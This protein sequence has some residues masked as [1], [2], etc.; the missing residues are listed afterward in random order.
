MIY[1]SLPSGCRYEVGS[2]GLLM[3]AWLPWLP[4]GSGGSYAIQTHCWFL[5]CMVPY[6]LLFDLLFRKVVLR[7]TTLSAGCVSLLLLALPPWIAFFVPGSLPEGD[8]KWYDSPAPLRLARLGPEMA[9][10]IHCAFS[11]LPLD[12]FACTAFPV[13][14]SCLHR[15]LCLPHPHR[16]RYSAHRVGALKS[17]VDYAI[18]TL[19][20]HPVCYLHVFVFGMVLARTRSLLAAELGA[21]ATGRSSVTGSVRREALGA[22]VL[23]PLFRFG[24]T[25]GYAGLAI[26][27]LVRGV[28]IQSPAL[29]TR[30]SILMPLQV[31]AIADAAACTTLLPRSPPEVL[32]LCMLPTQLD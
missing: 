7:L 32:L 9:C 2:Q 14:S 31:G 27:F 4:E 17:A 30:L 21:M 3:Q 13:P 5:S 24:A 15:M 16:R 20:F 1:H 22:R 25:I 6:W 26:I 28:R 12:R 10:L 23:E 29:S 8:D 19:K 18:I 11:R